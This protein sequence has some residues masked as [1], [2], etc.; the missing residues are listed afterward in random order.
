MS[1]YI[2]GPWYAQRGEDRKIM[3][4]LKANYSNGFYVD[5]GA[6]E[7]TLDSVTKHFYDRGWSG[8]NVE[9][10]PYYFERIVAERPRDINLDCAISNVNGRST[11]THYRN[12]GLSTF[13]E[14]Y[15]HEFRER[16][17]SEEI[18]VETRTLLSIFE[19][20]VPSEMRID[21][22]KID[23][24]GWEGHV[25]VG[26]DWERYRPELVV[27]EATKPGTEGANAVP[28]WDEWEHILLDANYKLCE[29]DGLNR[30]YQPRRR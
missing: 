24:E 7:P 8:I 27:V 10:I 22:L 30:W 4:Y 17:P 1:D 26:N 2:D 21:F 29:F 9:P 11:I 3:E 20:F 16:F 18:E 13:H 15:R 19:E 28:T 6:W 23:V 5:I 25:L 12:S 14:Q